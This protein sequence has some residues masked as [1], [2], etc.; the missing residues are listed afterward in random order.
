MPNP[1][2]SSN[3]RELTSNLAAY[4][5]QALAA[6]QQSTPGLAQMLAEITGSLSPQEAENQTSI[7]EQFG[8][9]INAAGSNI[10]NA[11]MLA[12]R[13]GE[14]AALSGPGQGLIDQAV[15][16]QQKVDPE[17]YKN[18]AMISEALQSFIKAGSPELS[19]TEMMQIQRGIGATGGMTTPSAMNTVKN[20]MTFGK[21]GT[22]KWTN[23]GN[24]VMGASSAL[25]NL[26]S[27]INAF[28]VGTG[29][30][31]NPNSGDQ[32]LLG[33]AQIN[34][35]SAMDANFGFANNILSNL[36]S[37]MTA[38]RGKPKDAWD[39][40]GIGAGAFGNIA[41]GVKSLYGAGGAF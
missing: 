11:R 21:A 38:Q 32:R 39:K 8:P 33:P 3:A 7:Y 27:G 14:L 35:S 18:Q 10:E 2:D 24:A 6:L 37:M 26:K 23:F 15:Q 5:P 28:E 17:F 9:R 30:A 20:A 12:A 36:G 41:G 31:L 16:G 40:V 4:Y 13:E 1:K 19:P 25:P 34:P 29:R 22:D